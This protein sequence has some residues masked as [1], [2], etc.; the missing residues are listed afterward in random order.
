MVTELK[1]HVIYPGLTLFSLHHWTYGVIME[2]WI[3]TVSWQ[4]IKTAPTSLSIQSKK[5]PDGVLSGYLIRL[6]GNMNSHNTA[7]FLLFITEMYPFTPHGGPN[8]PC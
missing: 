4:D 7:S 3:E 8:P 2:S 1:Q 5:Y 6:L